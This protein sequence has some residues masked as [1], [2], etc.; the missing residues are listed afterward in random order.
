MIQYAEDKGG[1]DGIVIK[2]IGVGGCGGNAV[3][4]MIEHGIDNVQYIA[5][6]TDLQALNRNHAATKIQLGEKCTRGLGA[7]SKP[8]VGREAAEE[9]KEEI[10]EQ[11]MGSHMLFITCGMGGGT[12]TGAAPV[13][14]EVAKELGVLTVGV[15]TKPFNSEG[16]CRRRHA[17]SGITNLKEFVDSL[18]IVPNEK[19]Y[20]LVP[21]ED[22]EIDMVDLY[23]MG[24]DVLFNAVRGISDII[25]KPGWVN[26]DFAD[27]M[28][29]MQ[30]QG[31]ALM[32]TGVANGQDRAQRALD[33]AINDP[34][35]EDVSIE[36]AMNILVNI[37]ASKIRPRE[38]NYITSTIESLANP[39]VHIIT[40]EVIDPSM[41]DDLKVTVIATGFDFDTVDADSNYVQA[42]VK[43]QNIQFNSIF[44]GN[45][46][47]ADK[48]RFSGSAPVSSAARQSSLPLDSDD[49]PAYIRLGKYPH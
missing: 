32:G 22:D 42:T 28:T 46:L 25:T 31:T 27:V 40:G 11:L 14:A 26:T 18:I 45:S 29:I 38:R 5:A 24:I 17:E 20:S 48:H 10:R 9:A 8:E 30:K 33:L 15:V 49:V 43:N 35:L 12:G 37:T 19:L 23:R 34:L 6:N 13:I 39:E 36:G 44:A 16:S 41:G 47:A 7:G 1:C 21:E 3:D 4:I 2:V